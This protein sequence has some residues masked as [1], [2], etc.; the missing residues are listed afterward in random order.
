MHVAP[1]PLG[2]W[3]RM[4]A[5][6]LLVSG[7]ALV[8][9][10]LGAATSLLLR[11]ALDP[12]QMGIWQGLRLFLSYANYANLGISK[13]AARELT[14]ALGRGNTSHAE[15]GLNL[16]FT[17]NTLSSLAYAAVLAG[18]GAWLAFSSGEIAG[19]PWAV[20][21]CVLGLLVVLQRHLTFHVTILRCRQAFGLTAQLSVIEGTLTLGVG[22]L[23]AWRWGLFGLYAGTLAVL[24]ASIA[25]LRWR[26]AAGFCWAWDRREIV[27]LI[28]VGGPILLA[29]VVTT[30]FQSLDKLMILTYSTERDFDL[31]CYS[32]SL[33]V[34]GQIFGL[35]NMLSLV[36]GPRYGE[37]F[38][39][40]GRRREVALLAARASELQAAMLAI[41]GGVAMVIAEPV[42]G[43]MLPAYRPGLLPAL[44]LVPGAVALGL[45]LPA[46]QYL[47]AVCR[48]RRALAAMVVATAAAAIG[49]HVAL[50]WGYGLVGVAIS[51]SLA[52]LASYV[53][54]VAISIWP[55]LDGRARWRYVAV[56]LF[57]LVPTL[58]LATVFEVHWPSDAAGTFD[59]AVNIA[60][61]FAVWSLT[62]LAGWQWGDWKR[63]WS[64]ERTHV[65]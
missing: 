7:S 15:R 29:G 62:M 43:R 61:V 5:D 35:A 24:L 50:T 6:S 51:T 33:L 1:A 64:A 60:L 38:G 8:C 56:V 27:R 53:L 41:L 13:G 28:G 48:E 59:T 30:L 37:L 47:V 17:V 46:S 18:T 31:G 58:A 9:Q 40:V 42:L 36:M 12:A 57:T 44:W 39:R 23:A 3:R 21:L 10:A 55:E 45:G 14:I 22:T 54:L 20:G 34:S 25:F 16:A 4:L 49:N 26:G 65:A 19:N 32:L 52:Y 63:A 11:L 2:G